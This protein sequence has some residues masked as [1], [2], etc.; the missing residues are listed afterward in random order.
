[1]D[2][3]RN[4][5]PVTAAGAGMGFRL[6]ASKAGTMDSG[7]ARY[8]DDL[9]EVIVCKDRSKWFIGDERAVLE[10]LG[11]FRAFD[12]V[13]EFCEALARYVTARHDTRLT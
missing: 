10:P 2:T 11:F 13:A 9:T 6:V 12:D 5:A 4:L 7:S 3:P 1:M 8:S